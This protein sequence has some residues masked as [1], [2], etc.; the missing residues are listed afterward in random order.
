MKKLFS[1][2]LL[3]PSILFSAGNFCEDEAK[4]YT[5]ETKIVN[6]TEELFD[7]A[8]ADQ[9]DILADYFAAIEVYVNGL[10]ALRRPD[11]VARIFERFQ[12]RGDSYAF[13]TRIC[14]EASIASKNGK[15][16][17]EKEALLISLIK[18][19]K[20]KSKGGAKDF[21]ASISEV[22]KSGNPIVKPSETLSNTIKE[23]CEKA[24]K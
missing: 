2:F 7:R 24:D 5:E 3:I 16:P 6:E 15:L 1:L 10:Q 14:L 8:K 18:E 12:E 17:K 22:L 9:S 23:L 4:A 21:E 11:R 13:A 19:A 20:K